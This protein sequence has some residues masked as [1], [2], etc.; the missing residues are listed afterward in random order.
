MKF[1]EARARAN[2]SPDAGLAC[3]GMTPNLEARLQMRTPSVT[4]G[5]VLQRLELREFLR[6]NSHVFG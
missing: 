6:A 1:G 4:N 5:S 3:G 2:S